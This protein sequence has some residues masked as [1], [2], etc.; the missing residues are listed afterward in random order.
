[1]TS[2]AP[3]HAGSAP[4]E[5]AEAF[6]LRLA[7]L[8]HA[9][10]TPAHRLERVLAK[11]AEAYGVQATFL[12]TPTAV[13]ASFGRGDKEHSHL[14]RIDP[15]ATDLG[16]LFEFDEIMDAAAD[17]ELSIAAARARLEE[18]A[19]AP[20]RWSPWASALAFAGASAGAACL[21]GGGL[22]DLC[23]TAV[24]GLVIALVERPIARAHGGPGLYEPVAAFVAAL[25][26]A[27]ASQL[28]RGVDKQLVT[29]SSLIVLLPGLTLTIAM[30]ELATRHLSSGVARLAGALM[31]FLA[32]LFGVALGWRTGDLV[33]IAPLGDVDPR[34]LPELA[35]WGAAGATAFTFCVLFHVRG[36]EVLPVV[37]T[38]L[39]GF[40]AARLAHVALPDFEPF[41]G[42]LAVGLASHVYARAVDRPSLVL[43]TPGILLLVPGSLGY[44]S[45]ESFLARDA[46]T[47]VQGAFQTGFVA[48]ALVG[49][50]LAAN[51]IL[52]PRR[53]L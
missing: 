46:V 51:L 49:G 15:G 13:I 53:V 6:L 19:S 34:P 10:G 47:G 50:L 4:R 3:L 21:L 28:V 35:V 2:D 45:L 48:V 18:I 43:Q 30:T 31:A 32:I 44:R 40:A 8:L 25:C 33:T 22:A 14:L 17:G 41:F 9:H 38:G 16:K 7:E 1:M 27:L 23:V 11:G 37:L 12:S 20:P 39:G 42:A 36:R 29:L 5:E 24:L 52:P 26:A